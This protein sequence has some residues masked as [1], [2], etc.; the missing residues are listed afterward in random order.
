VNTAGGYDLNFAGSSDKSRAF[1]YRAGGG[2]L[3][4]VGVGQDGTWAFLTKKRT[5]T[6]PTAGTVS[7]GWNAG[8]LSTQVNGVWQQSAFDTSD[9]LNTIMSVDTGTNSVRRDNVLN[10]TSMLTRPET[11]IL[12]T[13]GTTAREGFDYRKPET[14]LNSA[15]ASSNVVEFIRLPFRGMGFNAIVTGT[16]QFSLSV[17]KP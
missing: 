10:F 14:V 9:Y 5:N 7:T 4:I 8:T 13:V 6:L 2:E 16:S 15:G 12:N 3:M 17:A 1:A 11:V